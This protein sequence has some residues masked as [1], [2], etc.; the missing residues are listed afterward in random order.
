M[1][2]TSDTLLAFLIGAAMGGAAGLLLAPSTGTTT[3]KK[4]KKS[5]GELQSR[6]EDIY[7]DAEKAIEKKTDEIGRVA[8]NQVDAVKEALNEGKAAYLKELKNS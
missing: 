4:L 5:I 8:K 6:G 7:E 3:R 2:N 1:S